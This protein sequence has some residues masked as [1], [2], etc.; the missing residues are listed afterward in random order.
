MRFLLQGFY[1][2]FVLPVLCSCSNNK[3]EKVYQILHD[4][5]TTSYKLINQQNQLLLSSL[6]NKTWNAATAEK[7]KI[8]YPKALAVKQRTDALISSIEKMK[9]QSVKP[10]LFDSLEVFKTYILNIDPLIK[11]EFH[12][13]IILTDSGKYFDYEILD[14]NSGSAILSYFQNNVVM[15]ANKVIS[16][17]DEQVVDN[18]FYF[19]TFSAVV[20]QSSKYVRP[21][22]EVEIFAGVGSFSR[23][24]N[25]IVRVRGEEV[26]LSEDATA[27]YKFSAPNQIGK[28]QIP[29]EIEY[30]DQDGKRQIIYKTVEY[31]VM[32]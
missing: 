7:G 27:Q 14:G 28:H 4:G 32:K 30:S 6:E 2:V 26:P 24:T 20:G 9:G 29:V 1:I 11:E 16:F 25:P 13:K 23:R 3:K 15:S 22:D 19:T 5:L 8:W 10:T 21:S 31:T 12:N 17:C 18:S